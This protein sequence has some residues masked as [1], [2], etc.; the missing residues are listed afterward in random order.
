MVGPR[1]PLISFNTTNYNT[2]PITARSLDSLISRMKGVDYEIVCTDNYSDDGSYEVL[3]EYRDRGYPITLL[4]AKCGRGLG[5]QIALAKTHGEIVV[6]FDLDTVYNDDWERLFH[7]YLD[8]RPP[9]VLIA[10]Y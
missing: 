7:W 9:Y 4:R 10:T 8:R 6:T 3:A 5:R 2:A 1:R